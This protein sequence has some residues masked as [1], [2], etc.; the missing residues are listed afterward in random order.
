MSGTATYL[1]SKTLG[2]CVPAA[3][4]AVAAWQA[5]V[6][7][8][9]PQI[10]GKLEGAIRVQAALTVGFPE[11]DA[12]I[13]AAIQLVA[14][15]QTLLASNGPVVGLSVGAAAKL[16]AELTG[17]IGS[18]N[19]SLSAAAA[20]ALM[21]GTPGIEAY[22]YDG[23][24]DGLPTALSPEFVPGLRIGGGPTMPIHAVLLVATDGGAWTLMQ[25]V[26]AS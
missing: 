21:L 3:A 6:A 2:A 19:A 1:G 9:L 14:K 12:V 4:V 18:I 15:L 25:Q 22:R 7:L 20:M 23:T 17:S 10:Q 16:V 5:S 26:L 11:L 8:A 13:Q 24:A